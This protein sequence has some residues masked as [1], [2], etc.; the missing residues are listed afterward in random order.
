VNRVR[1]WLL[2]AGALAGLLLVALGSASAWLLYTPAGL[3]FVL[4]RGIAMMHGRFAYARADGTLAGEA[5]ITGLRYRDDGGDTLGIERATFDLR[6][7]SLLVRTLH[8]ARARIEGITLDIAPTGSPGES[9]AFSLKPPLAIALDDTRLTRIAV[10]ARGK[11]AFVANSLAISGSW[12]RRQLV[13]RHLA[14]RAPAGSADLEGSLALA[15]GYRGR[16]KATFQWSRGDTR[17]A[18]AVTSQSDGRSA[19]LQ[20]SLTS[21]VHLELAATVRLD[22]RRAWTLRLNAPTFDADALPNLP[23]GLKTLALEGAC[24]GRSLQTAT[25]S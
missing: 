25:R 4:G 9:N 13:I 3:R 23:A 1:Q 17:F 14:M 24:T 8:V 18:G 19:H 20:A 6:P 22:V 12:S 10:T 11:P 16:G 21:P 7:W 5:T 2:G 15:P